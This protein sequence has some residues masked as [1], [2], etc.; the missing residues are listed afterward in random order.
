[1]KLTKYIHSCMTLEKDGQVLVIDPGVYTTDLPAGLSQVVAT[2][3]THIHPDHFDPPHLLA[4]AANNPDM[5][6]VTGIDVA[7][8]MPAG[9]ATKVVEPG[10]SLIVE[11]F[12]LKFYGS[13]HA[14]VAPGLTDVPCLG[15]MVDGKLAYAGDAFP[16]PPSTPTALAVPVAGFW[17][18]GEDVLSYI[19][20]VRASLAFP[21][22][23]A[24]AS[25]RGMKLINATV[26]A[27]IAPE[28]TWKVLAPGQ[29]LEL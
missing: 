29:T 20:D 11:P 12:T 5:L 15:V 7:Q 22:H 14:R 26:D 23:E 9:I 25:D 16:A 4:L 2:V 13:R 1:M 8:Q 10:D 19:R 24:L 27:A 6:V 18:D 17:V 21:V 28:Q 3:V